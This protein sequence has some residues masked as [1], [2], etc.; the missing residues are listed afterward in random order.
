MR[1][2]ICSFNIMAPTQA[3]SALAAPDYR[4]RLSTPMT[5]IAT[6]CFPASLKFQSF[7]YGTAVAI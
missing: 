1:R 3:R 7:S 4:V 6:A 5:D 2:Q